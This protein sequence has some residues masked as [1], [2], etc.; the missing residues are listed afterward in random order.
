MSKIPL[1]LLPGFLC[2]RTVWEAQMSALADVADCT[3]MDW[4]T[5]DSLVDMAGKILDTAPP[6]FALAG[7]SMGGRI[8]FEVC[9]RAPERVTHVALMNTNFPPK[10][11]GEAGDT[12]ARGR[13][14]LLDLARSKG[15]RSMSQKW[16]QGMVPSY[17]Q[18]DVTL[19]ETIIKMF[20]RKT[21]DDFARQMKALLHR[22]DATPVLPL[23]RA[24]TLVLTG[25]DDQWSPPAAHQ[26]MQAAI[27]DSRLVLV[28]KCGHMSTMERPEA[29]SAAFREWLPAR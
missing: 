27:P 3:V 6:K 11:P 14:E 5:L 18:G 4:G 9:R 10:A 21:P 19:I 12:E 1:L 23:V 13:Q 26:K 2:D 28:P 29:V 8:A 16:L 17:R 25:D 24:K 22:P 15:M 20:E 7:H